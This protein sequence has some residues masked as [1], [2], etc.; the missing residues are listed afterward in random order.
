MALY[1]DSEL[2]IRA[3]LDAAHQKTIMSF[4][5]PGRWWSAK[6]RVAI[7]AAAR[8]A[9]CEAGL[10]DQSVQDPSAGV[11]PPAAEAVARRVAV[12][13]NDL[14]RGFY[15]QAITDG[16]SDAEYCEI[17]GVV[18]RASNVDV[19]ARGIGVP[20]RKLAQAGEEQPSR[21]RPEILL[22]EGAWTKTIPGGR[23]GKQEAMDTYGTN[24]VEGAPFIY[25]ALSLVPEEAQDLIALGASQYVE[26]ANF[27]DL[28]FTYEPTISR[29]QVEL[30]AA[31][32]SAIN[33]CFY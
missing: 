32:V 11:I 14:D 9:R 13:T 25:R 3:S 27:M 19:F 24:A 8:D 29:Q 22:D 4:S 18:A 5:A 21:V 7:V 16:L 26:I 1:P 17:V 30:L 23:R 2:T 28:N 12:S 31:R 6:Q 33:E 10:Q 20:P 15:D